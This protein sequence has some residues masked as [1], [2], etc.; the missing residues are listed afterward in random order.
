M[1]DLAAPMNI[2]RKDVE[3]VGGHGFSI[4]LDPKR[5]KLHL[6]VWYGRY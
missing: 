3:V 4:F 1:V 6:Q 5:I 2:K